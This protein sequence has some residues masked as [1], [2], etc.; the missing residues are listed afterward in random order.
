MALG[1]NHVHVATTVNP[2]GVDLEEQGRFAEAEKLHE[3]ILA[4]RKTTLGENHPD[5]AQILNNLG[6]VRRK[7]GNFVHSEDLHQKAI[8]IGMAS[9]GK[10]T[11]M[12]SKASTTWEGR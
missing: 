9:L 5:V 3:S 2:R 4:I 11:L 12:W 1:E 8:K 6:I 7:R 10:S